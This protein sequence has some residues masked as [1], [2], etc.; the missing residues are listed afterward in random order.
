MS[1]SGPG[2]NLPPIRCVPGVLTL[3]WLGHEATHSPATSDEV[4]NECSYTSTP[5]TCLHG[6]YKDNLTSPVNNTHFH[7]RSTVH[8]VNTK[9]KYSLCK[10]NA[11]CFK[12]SL[13]QDGIKIFDSLPSS[14]KRTMKGREIFKI[15]LNILTNTFLLWSS[16]IFHF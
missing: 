16:W 2:S 15:Q 10:I 11:T 4:K 5:L 13:Y 14:R 7:S 1:I 6:M 8:S 12:K 3:K 9:T